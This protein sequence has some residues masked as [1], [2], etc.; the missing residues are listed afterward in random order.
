VGQITPETE[1]PSMSCRPNREDRLALTPWF[2]NESTAQR[3]QLLLTPAYH[4]RMRVYFDKYVC[5]RC[6]RKLVP[7][8]CN[9]LCLAY[10]GLIAH[11]LKR[12]DKKLKLEL[13][14][15]SPRGVTDFLMR[16]ESARTLL[17]DLRPSKLPPRRFRQRAF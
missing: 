7:Y 4:K 12:I 10:V 9:G 5:I 1:R 16:R 13:G 6:Q 8:C 11:R 14:S 17:A 3:V 15:A 2:L